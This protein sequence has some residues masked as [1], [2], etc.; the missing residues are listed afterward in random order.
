MPVAIL[1]CEGN[2][3]SPDIRILKKLLGNTCLVQP[4]GSVRGLRERVEFAR[5]LLKS[6]AVFAIRDRDFPKPGKWLLEDRD[7]VLLWETYGSDSQTHHWGWTWARKEIE[8]YLI[9][10]A[11][12]QKSLEVHSHKNTWD[13]KSFN[14]DDYQKELERVKD[15]LAPYQAARIA[16]AAAGK[17]PYL[18]TQ[19]GKP[20]GH[21]NYHFPDNYDKTACENQIRAIIQEH[22]QNAASANEVLENFRQI[23]MEECQS[24]KQRNLDYLYAF[25]GKDILWGMVPWFAKT[26]FKNI[27][28][29]QEKIL[30]GIERAENSITLWCGEWND[31]LTKVIQ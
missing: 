1:L 12:V 24:G 20:R 14:L 28:R 19:F 29:F 26:P 10:P 17:K 11:I 3:Q 7:A 6:E 25:S 22:E 16:L 21:N 31:L 18:P 4:H 2:E 30:T 15:F 9:D 13:P 5:I 8:N 23:F 27:A